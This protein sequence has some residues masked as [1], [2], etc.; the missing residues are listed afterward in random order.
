MT[1]SLIY[2]IDFSCQIQ[3]LLLKKLNFNFQV[4]YQNLSN[5]NLICQIVK[6]Q[7]FPGKMTTLLLNLFL[8]YHCHIIIFIETLTKNKLYGI[9]LS[10]I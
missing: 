2:M 5:S 9:F 7:V 8:N 4:F 3:I 10:L 6:F 1:K